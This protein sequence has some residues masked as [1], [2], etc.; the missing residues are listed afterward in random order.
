MEILSVRLTGVAPLI[1]H[2]GRLADPLDDVAVE[3]ARFTSKRKK[4]ISDHRRIA[5]LEFLG[6]MWVVDDQPCIPAEAVEASICQAAASRRAK[7][8]FRSGVSVQTNAILQHPGPGTIDGLLRDP[9]YRLRVPVAIGG[10]RL[11]RTRPRFCQW[12]VMEAIGY[13][14]SLVNSTDLIEVL[15]MAGDQVGVGDWRPKF[16]RFVVNV[17]E[18]TAPQSLSPTSSARHG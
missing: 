14:P 18:P 12:W 4:T 2:A 17:E 1:M 15:M 8:I 11:M 7:S 10:R 9:N 5:D 3:L 6:G 16:G 13:L